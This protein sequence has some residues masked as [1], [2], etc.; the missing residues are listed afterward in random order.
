MRKSNSL[1]AHLDWPLLASFF[2]LLF[3]GIATVYSV[4][5]SEEHPNIFSLS[6]KYG[7]S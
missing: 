1:L 6:E 7:K 3:F 4:S 2:V 5:F